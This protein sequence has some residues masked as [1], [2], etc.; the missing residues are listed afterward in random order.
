MDF[1]VVIL[2]QIRENYKPLL[3]L[4]SGTAL[5]FIISKYYK[6]RSCSCTSSSKNVTKELPSIEDIQRFI[7]ELP[8]DT[9]QLENTQEGL[10]ELLGELSEISDDEEWRE[11]VASLQRFYEESA[12]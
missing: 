7:E 5:Y 11:L 6:M 3:L 12:E 1:K 2:D 4:L 10:K 9:S 8:L